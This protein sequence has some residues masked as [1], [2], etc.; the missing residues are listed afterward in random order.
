M[1]TSGTS[2]TRPNALRQHFAVSLSWECGHISTNSVLCFWLAGLDSRATLTSRRCAA[3]RT[4]WLSAVRHFHLA[5]PLRSFDVGRECKIHL[6]ACWKY[7]INYSLTSIQN[8]QLD[9]A[10]VARCTLSVSCS[11]YLDYCIVFVH[12]VGVFLEHLHRTLEASER[13]TSRLP[14]RFSVYC[15]PFGP[16]SKHHS[17]CNIYL[18][19]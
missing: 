19:S 15:V 1:K 10:E 5:F 18:K 6:T 14:R 8:T 17:C 12:R 16:R 11:I 7:I 2:V 3:S 4:D 13:F 9:R